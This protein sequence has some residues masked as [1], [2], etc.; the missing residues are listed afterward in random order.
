MYFVYSLLPFTLF[1]M[2]L[3]AFLKPYLK[4]PGRED[5]GRFF[6]MFLSCSAV[7]L[8]TSIIDKSGMLSSLVEK[9]SFGILEYSFVR[10]FIFPALL[11]ASAKILDLYDKKKAEDFQKERA[12][13]YS[14]KQYISRD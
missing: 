2:A 9:F 12:K 8:V 14:Y 6:M 11:F 1:V 4:V 3:W 7:L 10:W 5:A 13:T